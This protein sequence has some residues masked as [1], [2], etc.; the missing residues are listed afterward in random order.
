MLLKSDA[1]STESDNLFILSRC[2]TE[3]YNLFSQSQIMSYFVHKLLQSTL[4]YVHIFACKCPDVKDLRI[5]LVL[6][7][8]EIAIRG[9]S[10]FVRDMRMLLG[11]RDLDI[12]NP[13]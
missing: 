11:P 7:A 5:V 1:L 12:G 3:I 2:D 13:L 4:V 6:R 10:L 8:F 9:K